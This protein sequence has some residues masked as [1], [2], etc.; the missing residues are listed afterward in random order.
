MGLL[1]HHHRRFASLAARISGAPPAVG[2]RT[3]TSMP[4]LPPPQSPA[5]APQSHGPQSHN[6]ASHHQATAGQLHVQQLRI[7]GLVVVSTETTKENYDSHPLLPLS[8]QPTSLDA[9]DWS[10]AAEMPAIYLRAQAPDTRRRG[11]HLKS[12]PGNISKRRSI[13]H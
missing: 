3:A 8:A 13:L 2:R 6:A 1:R 11:D 7:V 4:A 12:N 5:P 9:G 10:E